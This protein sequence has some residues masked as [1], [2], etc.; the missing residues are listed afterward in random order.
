MS[1]SVKLFVLSLLTLAL[2]NALQAQK[3]P[4]H[5]QA[6]TSETNQGNFAHCRYPSIKS[7]ISTLYDLPAE[8][9]ET[10]GLAWHNGRLFTHND[11]KHQPI[12]YAL[13]PENGQIL[14]RI[15]VTN[16]V[17]VDWEELAADDTYLYIGDFGNNS[18]QRREFQIYRVAWN[19][20]PESG[21]ADVQADT[22]VFTYPN[23]P[24]NL[25]YLAHN[26]DCEAMIATDEALYLFSKNWADGRTFLYSLPKQPGKWKAEFAG[27]FNSAGLITG[28]DYQP[29]TGLL[30][31]VGYT[32]RTWKPFAWVLNDFAGNDFF[33]GNKL[34]INL[35][36]LV[37][38]QIEGVVFQAPAKVRIT[39]ERSKAS[40]ARA[41]ELDANNII[42]IDQPPLSH[43]HA[44]CGRKL[45]LEQSPEGIAIHFS[46]RQKQPLVVYFEDEAS[47]V[48][49]YQRLHPCR[50]KKSSFLPTASI[51][52]STAFLLIS[53]PKFQTRC[54]IR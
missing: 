27:V 39:S 34:R 35:K 18:G 42:S 52:D 53:T 45:R 5:R 21:D 17:N 9:R 6:G 49:H 22:I 54:P 2:A 33:S 41:F 28:A 48:M 29:E 43:P 38:N 50:N 4:R 30:V 3:I 11:S 23:Q 14:Q 26:F 20:I 44:D 37:A 16:A 7:S 1:G 32:N 31:L 24:E 40:P 10:S 36:G 13:S 19:N 51:P 46:R 12:V 47:Q 8:V 25:R 15:R